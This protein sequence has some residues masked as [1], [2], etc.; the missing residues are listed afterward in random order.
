MAIVAPLIGAGI[1]LLG[2]LLG[3]DERSKGAREAREQSQQALGLYNNLNVPTAEEQALYLNIAN[4]VGEYNPNSQQAENLGP[5]ASQ[6]VYADQ[7]TIDTQK[8]VLQKMLDA[9]N[10]GGLSD[11]D[12]AAYRMMQRKVSNADTSRQ[13][14]IINNMAQRGTAGSGA[15][16]AARLQG[17]Q[18]AS[19]QA[20]NASDN[21]LAEGRSRALQALSQTGSMA[22]NLRSQ[23]FG[24]QS[25]RA[26]AAD[27]INKFNT[28]NRQ[29]VSNAN[30]NAQNEAQ[31]ANLQNKQS[32]ENARVATLNAQQ[33]HNTGLKRQVFNDRLNLAGAKSNIMTGQANQIIQNA[34]ANANAI[35][36]GAS[37]LTGLVSAFG[38]PDKTS[39]TGKNGKG[40]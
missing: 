36:G 20:A 17:S 11:A 12:E 40:K 4:L 33:Q 21:I 29:D 34:N 9:S 5:S 24:E 14:A 27:A 10:N 39:D 3:N 38:A 35:T 7:Q 28:Q 6:N 15:E 13:K 31:M 30:V 2:G 16:L 25:D 18:E 19:D 1:S 32:I 26:R 23:D 22:Q 8:A 37:A